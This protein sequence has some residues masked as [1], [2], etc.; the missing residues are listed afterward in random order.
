MVWLVVGG[1]VL[2]SSLYEVDGSGPVLPYLFRPR[3]P[4]EVEACARHPFRV[5]PVD[6]RIPVGPEASAG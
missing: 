5:G 4:V 6:Y 2:L 1:C 3:L